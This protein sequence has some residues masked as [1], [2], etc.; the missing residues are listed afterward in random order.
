MF[1]YDTALCQIDIYFI[2]ANICHV[3]MAGAAIIQIRA[4][5]GQGKKPH[6]KQDTQ[7]FVR[8]FPGIERLERIIQELKN[9]HLLFAF[10][11]GIVDELRPVAG[12]SG[13]GDIPPDMVQRAGKR[14]LILLHVESLVTTMRP[15][16]SNSLPLL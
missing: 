7:H 15:F 11:Q 6:L 1:A 3:R 2:L 10:F 13:F 12:K 4:Q 5:P 16:V 8:Y 14:V 9:S